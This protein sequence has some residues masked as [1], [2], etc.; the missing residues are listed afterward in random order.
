ML[1]TASALMASTS[2]TH[3]Q[4]AFEAAQGRGQESAAQTAASAPPSLEAVATDALDRDTTAFDFVEG[5]T[6]EVGPR[7]AGTEAEARAR[8]WAMAWLKR[9]F[10]RWPG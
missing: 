5:I 4:S 10:W 8:D 6:T 7:Q 3:A 9:R 1:L 2:V